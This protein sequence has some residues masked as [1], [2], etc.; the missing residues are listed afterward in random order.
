MQF[1]SILFIL[2]FNSQIFVFIRVHSWF[3][4]TRSWVNDYVD[5][6]LCLAHALTR[7]RAAVRAKQKRPAIVGF[8]GC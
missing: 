8:A 6:S 2:L 4:N 7:L 1:L 3:I 5:V